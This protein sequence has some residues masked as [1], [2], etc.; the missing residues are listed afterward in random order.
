MK[1]ILGKNITAFRNKLNLSQKQVADFLGIKRENISY[2]ENGSRSIPLEHREKLADLF[3]VE[4]YDLST[5]DLSNQKADLAFAFRADE[6]NSEDLENIS[7][8][9][10]IVKNYIKMKEFAA[11]HETSS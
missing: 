9:K 10:K 2:Y 4:I 1:D 3:G 7:R 6:I 5:S 11:S 8:F